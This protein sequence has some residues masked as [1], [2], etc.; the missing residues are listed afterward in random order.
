MNRRSL[1]LIVATTVLIVLGLTVM[2][3]AEPQAPRSAAGGGAF[4]QVEAGATATVYLRGNVSGV[5]FTERSADGFL[6]SRSGKIAALDE[7]WLVLENKTG[8]KS[9]IPLDAIAVIDTDGK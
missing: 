9:I 6:L 8:G 3:R 7:K 1:P 2:N 4:S 5:A